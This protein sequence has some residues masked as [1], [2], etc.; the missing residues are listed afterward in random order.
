MNP[1]EPFDCPNA[2]PFR[3]GSHYRDLL[4]STQDVCHVL[5]VHEQILLRQ[6]NFSY[7]KKKADGFYSIGFLTRWGRF[8]CLEARNGIYTRRKLFAQWGSIPTGSILKFMR[9]VR[10]FS[11]RPSKVPL[12]SILCEKR[13]LYGLHPRSAWLRFHAP[14]LA[15]QK[16]ANP[17]FG[18]AAY[19][20]ASARRF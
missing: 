20:G 7:T 1:G 8:R 2:G 5:F 18:R 12:S 4:F 14:S 6:L 19:H 9:S 10:P 13:P 3:E 16:A 11:E 17:A 15:A